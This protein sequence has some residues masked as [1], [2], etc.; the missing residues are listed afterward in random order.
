MFPHAILHEASVTF[1]GFG[2]SPEKPAIGMI[3]IG[4]YGVSEHGEMVAGAFSG[5]VACTRCG[6]V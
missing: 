3:L 2:L 1:L 4:K 6:L 5:I